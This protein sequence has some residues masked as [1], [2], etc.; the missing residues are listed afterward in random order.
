M[1]KR[2]AGKTK[3]NKRALGS[4]QYA[5]HEVRFGKMPSYEAQKMFNIPRRTILN[6]AR[7]KHTKTP[8]GQ[9]KLKPEEEKQFVNVLIVAADLGSPLT[10]L[11]LRIVVHEYLK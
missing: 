11:D 10:E 1:A 3:Q 9:I 7:N 4:R 2:K 5:E 6:K 8:G